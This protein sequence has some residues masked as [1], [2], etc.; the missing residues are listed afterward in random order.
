[1]ENTGN[2]GNQNIFIFAIFTMSL[3]FGIIKYK[4]SYHLFFVLINKIHHYSTNSIQQIYHYLHDNNKDLKEILKEDLKEELKEEKLEKYEDKYLVDIRQM[5]NEYKWNDFEKEIKNTKFMEFLN[6]LTN[7]DTNNLR[8][9]EVELTDIEIRLS[10]Y[11]GLEKD[12]CI[13]N[14][15]T[16]EENKS[17]TF[18]K[19]E[20]LKDNEGAEELKDNEGAE[21]KEEESKEESKEEFIIEL[22]TKKIQVLGKYNELKM[23]MNS[24]NYKR[25]NEIKAQEMAT[26]FINTQRTEKLKNNFV[27]ETTPLGN[28]LMTYDYVKESF[29]Y[30]SDN[31]IPYR[32]LEP[33]A[34]KFVKQFDC[35][36][37]FID[38]EEELKIQQE[39]MDKEN[40]ENE[41]KIQQEKEKIEDAIKNNLPQIPQKKNVFTK[42]KSYN[43]EFGRVNT[44][45]PPKNSIPNNK[46]NTNTN[47]SREKALLKDKSNRYT[48]E[49]KLINFSFIK[50]VDRKTVD[51]KYAMTFADFKKMNKIK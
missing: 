29:T 33:V 39:K 42:F 31:S 37:I 11:K 17:K 14:Y 25:E 18:F 34:R 22:E 35:K 51:K 16:D 13:Y 7:N 15:E 32:Y 28:V 5:K 23:K 49:G 27:I 24:N 47:N 2:I 26:Q 19:E 3:C 45:P 4:Q 40:L 46:S 21:E 48:Y 50:K 44:A 43:K 38:M 6:E 30:Y 20:K 36:P 8:D 41:L 10:K 1:M 12:Y 9:I